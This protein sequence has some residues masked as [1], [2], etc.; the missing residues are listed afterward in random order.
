MALRLA[1][2]ASYLA[3]S[4]TWHRTLLPQTREHP[5]QFF[6]STGGAI[7]ASAAN[8][9]NY[10]Q[11]AYY[12]LGEGETLLIDFAPPESVYWNLTSATIWHESQRH[13]TDPVS[14]T[15]SEALRSADGRV[16]FVVAARDPGSPNWIKTF[17]HERGFLLFRIVGV[18][19][20][21]LPTVERLK[22]SDLPA[23]LGIGAPAHSRGMS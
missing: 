15:S 4:S 16:R 14:L 12:E 22:S 17:G 20:H 7:G 1:K 5:N 10:Y 8:L 19:E 11:M 18:R 9:E 3:V 21:P 6:A 13:L 2:L 23:R